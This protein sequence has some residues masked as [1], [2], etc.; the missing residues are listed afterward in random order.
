MTDV[1]DE[2]EELVT[3]E[4]L[5]ATLGTCVDGRPHVAPLWY[6]YDDGPPFGRSP[7][8]SSL[9]SF[10]DDHIRGGVTNRNNPLHFCS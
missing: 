6:R 8:E 3:S 5:V 7:G 4:P 2:V 1:P 10:R 9:V